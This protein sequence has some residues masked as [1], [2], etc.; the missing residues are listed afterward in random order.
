[1]K[2]WDTSALIHLMVQQG[3]IH[4]VAR[5]IK[6]DQEISTWW[7]TR[8]ECVSGLTRLSRERHLDDDGLKAALEGLVT[9]CENWVEIQP[10]I[11]LREIATRCL[12]THP[13]QAADALQ[14]AAAWVASEQKPSTLEFVTLDKRLAEAASKEGFRVLP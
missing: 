12:R 3:S 4:K 8:V 14:L 10:S 13:L 2:F 1:M 9:M 7:G 5:I 11:P 6:R